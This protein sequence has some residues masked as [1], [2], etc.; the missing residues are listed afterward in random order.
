MEPLLTMKQILE[1]DMHGQ[2]RG[3]RQASM[4]LEAALI[5]LESNEEYQRYDSI[6]VSDFEG[7]TARINAREKLPDSVK[8]L[9]NT[10]DYYQELA[11]ELPFQLYLKS[12]HDAVRE[13]M[14]REILSFLLFHLSFF[15]YEPC[16]TFLHDM[17]YMQGSQPRAARQHDE[18]AGIPASISDDFTDAGND[19]L[20]VIDAIEAMGLINNPDVKAEQNLT[21]RGQAVL[22]LLDD[23]RGP[24]QAAKIKARMDA[25]LP[26]DPGMLPC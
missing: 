4:Y 20:S 19:N 18:S 23:M 17:L 8:E 24:C 25:A 26:P 3:Y 15:G 5:A 7:I 1:S 6:D 12:S 22:R 16:A 21:E 13:V 2:L 14:A 11:G 10:R 9:M